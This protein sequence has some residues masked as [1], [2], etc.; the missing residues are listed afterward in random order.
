LWW[1]IPVINEV[2]R[3]RQEDNEFET[4]LGYTSNEGQEHKTDHSKGRV[5]VGEE[6][7]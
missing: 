3:M 5:V 1:D 7:K 4:S 2:K 6:V